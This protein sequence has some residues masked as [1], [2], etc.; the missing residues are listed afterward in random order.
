[1]NNEKIGMIIGIFLLVLG[2]VILLYVLTSAM[3]IVQNPG[4]FFEEQFP[5]E[6]KSQEGPNAQFSWDTNDQTVDF[7][8][9]SEEG[10]APISNWEWEFGDG[11]RSY[12]QNPQHTF[13]SNGDY[14]VSLRVE[15]ENGKSS[16]THADVYVEFGRNDGG[17]SE[18]EFGDISFEMGNFM[19]PFAAALLLGMLY[20]VMFLVGAALTKA[21][22]NLIKPGPSTLKLKIKPKRLEVEQAEGQSEYATQPAPAANPAATDPYP[23][24]SPAPTSA[25]VIASLESLPSTH[26]QPMHPTYAQPNQ[27]QNYQSAYAPQPVPPQHPPIDTPQPIPG[28]PS[29][30]SQTDITNFSEPSPIP[31]Q[32]LPSETSSRPKTEVD[33][34]ITPNTP[35]KSTKPK[36]ES[37]QTK[38]QSSTGPQQPA[39]QTVTGAQPRVHPQQA[40][41][42]RQ[43]YPSSQGRGR[44]ND[45]RQQYRGPPPNSS[46]VKGKGSPFKGGSK[47]RGRRKGKKR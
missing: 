25:A 15:D 29:P 11:E 19:L 37:K 10:D 39:K 36:E 26:G 9:E 12:E 13:Y 27:G 32:E 38:F 1:M 18:A 44:P 35:S 22:W 30:F 2:I 31:Q 47:G 3:A 34:Q 41:T 42:S 16:T 33:K 17:R 24:Y 4:T 21:G 28:G 45:P 23:A 40:P 7:R 6:E 20:C 8:D 43:P 5:E 14:R 46:R